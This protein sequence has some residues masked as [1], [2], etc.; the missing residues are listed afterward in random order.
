MKN[1]GQALTEF[2]ILLPVLML[3][4][5]GMVDFG[6]IIYQKYKLESDLDTIVELYQND[7]IDRIT[8]YAEKEG[9]TSSLEENNEMTT[10]SITKKVPIYTP[11]LNRVL[12]NPYL[13]TGRRMVYHES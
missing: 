11:G 1:K 6:N 9:I 2:I 3:L 4:I 12:K 13:L 8:L 7:K 5:I 10:I